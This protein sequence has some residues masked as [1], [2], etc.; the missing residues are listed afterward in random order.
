[1]RNFNKTP[2]KSLRKNRTPDAV[3]VKSGANCDC[4]VDGKLKFKRVLVKLKKY[5]K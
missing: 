5:A 1:M 2:T 4:W 3:S